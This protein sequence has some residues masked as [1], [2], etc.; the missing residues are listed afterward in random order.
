MP[1]PILMPALSPTMTEGNLARWLKKEG[2]EVHAGEVLAEIETDKAT[3]EFEAV[4]E[5]RL[6]KIL[7]PEGTQGVKVNDPIA[8]LLEAG[9]DASALA[10][11]RPAEK[12]QAPPREKPQ[13][14]QARETAAKAP[15]SALPEK[16]TRRAG[17]RLFASP[18][19]RRMAAEA[20]FD[21]AA[22]SGSGP[23]GR[24]VKADVEAALSARGEAQPQKE[25][26]P[27]ASSLARARV[28]ALAGNLPYKE[29][30]LTQMRRIIARRLLESKQTIPHF[31]LSVDCEIDELLKIRASLNAKS[32]AYRLTVNDFVIRAAALALREVPEA[33]ASWSEEAILLWQSVDI[34]VAVALDEGLI[35]PIVKAADTKGLLS[36]AREM[37]DLSTRAREGKLR[38][39]EFQGGTFSISNL[40]M[41]AVR[42]FAAV[43]NPPQG[44]IL[45]VGA[46]EKRPVVK[47]GALAVASVMTATLS[48]DHRV[49]DG[50][51]AARFLAAF[52]RLIEDPLTMLL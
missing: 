29:K 42:E 49:V 52:K 21:L 48:C 14:P 27:P 9:E 5:G 23:E 31:Y 2:E 8:L 19:A 47:E 37:R 43:I 36:I 11:A 33:N 39:E 30:P 22:I 3:M 15:S 50:V 28:A 34:A 40:G 35:T 10:E 18:L 24:I 12:P 1:I 41:F 20:G 38:L 46:G 51:I 16:E 7:V 4:D 6:G 13:E 25:A 17:A 26:A 44:A 45:A 32:E